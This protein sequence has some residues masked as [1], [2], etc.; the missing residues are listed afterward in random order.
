MFVSALQLPRRYFGGS[1]HVT[2]YLG[3]QNDPSSSFSCAP[4][5][6]GAEVRVDTR[7]FRCRGITIRFRSDV[8]VC[9]AANSW[10]SWESVATGDSL[11]RV[12]LPTHE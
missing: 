12:L 11:L 10:L 1:G 9:G 6:A 3:A 4:F 5:F 2:D 8:A 7:P